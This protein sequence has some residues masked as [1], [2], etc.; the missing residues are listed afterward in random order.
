MWTHRCLATA[1]TMWEARSAA[2]ILGRGVSRAALIWLLV[3]MQAAAEDVAAP[4]PEADLPPAKA[5]VLA[6]DTIWEMPLHW[7]QEGA[8]TRLAASVGTA[9]ARTFHVL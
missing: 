8:G 3:L 5:V 9:G 4:V 1:A 7:A 6:L 2:A